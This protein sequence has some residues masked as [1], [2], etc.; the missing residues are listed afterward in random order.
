LKIRF[1]D[2]DGNPRAFI[3]MRPSGTEPVFRIMCDV[4]GGDEAAERSLLR[5]ETTLL[6]KADGAE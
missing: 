1:L 3:W 5:W 4:M 2:E 6:K